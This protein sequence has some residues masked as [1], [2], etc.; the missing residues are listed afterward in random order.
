[1]NIEEIK[2][3]FGDCDWMRVFLNCYTVDA[4]LWLIDRVDTLEKAEN[5]QGILGWQDYSHRC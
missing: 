4:I 3:E 2:K 1:M 5:C